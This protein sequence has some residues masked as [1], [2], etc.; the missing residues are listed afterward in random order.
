MW[1]PVCGRNA[2]ICPGREGSNLAK[3]AFHPQSGPESRSF[4]DREP[5]GRK[6]SLENARPALEDRL[7]AADIMG[8]K[9]GEGDAVRE[10]LFVHPEEKMQTLRKESK[11]RAGVSCACSPTT[12]PNPSCPGGGQGHTVYIQ[13]SKSL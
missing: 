1:N 12:E 10:G 3:G 9:A 2:G 7:F 11:C 5:D 6:E 13:C 8:R 4:E